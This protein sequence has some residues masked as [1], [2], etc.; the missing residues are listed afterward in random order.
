MP[1]LRRIGAC[2]AAALLFIG[3]GGCQIIGGIAYNIERTGSHEVN[4]EYEGLQGKRV[5]VLVAADRVILANYPQLTTQLTSFISQRLATDANV[6][7]GVI[8]PTAVLKY[9]FDHPR[10]L[11]KSYGELAK[12]FGVDR[13][14]MIDLFEFRLNEPGNRYLWD[15]LAAAKIGVTEADGP[16]PDEFVYSKDISVSFPDKEAGPSDYSQSQVESVL[17][18]RFVDRVVWLFYKHEEANVIPY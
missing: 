16:S 10:W 17:R 18:K 14:V 9:Q 4:A 3:G 7:T 13:V 12:D 5:V 1:G 15:G 2:V 11:Y 6:G 8:S